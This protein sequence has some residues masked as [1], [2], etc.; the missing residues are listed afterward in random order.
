M[1]KSLTAMLYG[2][3]LQR[4]GEDFD[5]E[6]PAP[7][8]A[9]KEGDPRRK[10]T[11]GNLMQMSSGLRFSHTQDKEGLWDH[12]Y[13][14]HF[15]V[16]GGAID[17]FSFVASR[18]PE[19]A[20]GTIGRYRNCDPLLIGSIVKQRLTELGESYLRFPQHELFDPLGIDGIVLET[21]P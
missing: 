13:P 20:P 10:I 18:S 9:W 14:D 16:Y 4:E 2:R 5:P 1:G 8:P 12:G 21:D 17:V 3:L 11:I 6:L 19:H 15:Y 7:I